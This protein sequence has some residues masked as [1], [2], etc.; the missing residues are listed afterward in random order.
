MPLTLAPPGPH[1]QSEATATYQSHPIFKPGGTATPFRGKGQM[2]WR[3]MAGHFRECWRRRSDTPAG[4]VCLCVFVCVCVCVCAC[5]RVCV[6]ACV[7]VCVCACVCV[8]V[9]V[10]C[11][12]TLMSCPGRCATET[13]S[14]QG[15]AFQ[16]HKC[17][18]AHSS[19]DASP[20]GSK[21]LPLFVPPSPPHVWINFQKGNVSV[22]V[23]VCV[24]VRSEERCVVKE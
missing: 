3:S 9:C 18:G 15:G 1:S 8:C 10:S 22:C 13:R 24:C 20:P 19:Q 4:C 16:W 23:C 21:S 2:L 6:C 14:W 12:I 5:V 11:G 7:R 17:H